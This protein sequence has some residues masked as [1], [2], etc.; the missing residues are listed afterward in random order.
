MS[1]KDNPLYSNPASGQNGKGR[2]PEKGRALDKFRAG[3]DGINW[4]RKPK[5]A[6]KKKV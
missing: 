2:G 5:P 3:Y 1:T 4:G 6:P